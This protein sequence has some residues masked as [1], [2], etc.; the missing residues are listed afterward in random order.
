MDDQP[1]GGVRAPAAGEPLPDPPNPRLVAPVRWRR[2]AGDEVEQW[3]EKQA[4]W[5]RQRAWSGDVLEGLEKGEGF[6]DLVARVLCRHPDVLDATRAART[7]RNFLYNLRRQGA[8]GMDFPPPPPV[9]AG[10]YETLRELG[11]GGVGVAW[12]AR[13][14][15]TD[16]EVVVKHA[17]DYFAPMARTEAN[18]RR[19]VDVMRRLDHP[20]IV[21][22]AD[23]FEREGRIHLVRDFVDG[24]DL[25]SARPKDVDGLRR[26]L[27]RVLE[28]LD[29]AHGRGLL[30][31]DLRPAN[32][33]RGLDGAPML[34]DVGTFADMV[35]GAATFERAVGSPGFASPEMVAQR[36]VTVRSDVW[37]AGRLAFALATGLVPQKQWT[38]KDVEARL[39]DHPLRA[40][41]L[42]WC[43]DRVEDRPID[44][45][46]AAASLSG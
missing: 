27:R 45:R 25:L 34:I 20:G 8:V 13:D 28:I 3:N 33:L 17:W 9:F 19:E 29:H 24:D 5:V 26:D 42:A 21:R 11:R 23:V 31:L 22:A 37:G 2:I 18:L 43:A 15:E 35:D 30:A 38:V 44:A 10:R 41:V 1:A 12:L 40:A 16:R 14:R 39:A 4:R 46:A 6:R 7:V 32:F 36:R